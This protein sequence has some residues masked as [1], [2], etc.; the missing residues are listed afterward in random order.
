MTHVQKS[1]K[2]NLIHIAQYIFSVELKFVVVTSNMCMCIFLHFFIALCSWGCVLSFA[3]VSLISCSGQKGKLFTN[4]SYKQMVLMMPKLLLM[5]LKKSL[6]YSNFEMMAHVCSSFVSHL[7]YHHL[8]FFHNPSLMWSCFLDFWYLIMPVCITLIKLLS[9]S[10]QCC[11]SCKP[12]IFS[13]LQRVSV[14]VN[15]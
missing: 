1:Y 12:K 3:V 8:L 10:S 5:G 15:P 11:Q 2:T 9:F 14:S 4:S 13:Q 7:F 6:H